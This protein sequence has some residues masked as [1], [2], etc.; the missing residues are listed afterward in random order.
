MRTGWTDKEASPVLGVHP[1][2]VSQSLTPALRKV[3][4]L[5]LADPLRTLD[6]LREAM[7]DIQASD[8][9]S[10]TNGRYRP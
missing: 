1:S 4:L 8:Q 10:T 2:K 6:A 5:M 3:A 9:T 7:G